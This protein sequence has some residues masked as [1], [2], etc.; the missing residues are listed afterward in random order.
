MLNRWLMSLDAFGLVVAINNLA[1]A[2]PPACQG[3]YSPQ[4]VRSG[5]L[6]IPALR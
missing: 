5:Q 4:L 6:R 1:L 3:G 2:R